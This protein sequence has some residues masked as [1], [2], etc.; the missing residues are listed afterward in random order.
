[1][2]VVQSDLFENLPPE[3]KDRVIFNPPFWDKARD[4]QNPLTYASCD[5]GRNVLKKFLATVPDFLSHTDS[6]V[7]MVFSTQD[8]FSQVERI[9]TT[10]KGLTVKNTTTET[11]G[12][13]RVLFS[14]GRD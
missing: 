5:E 14:L 4:P 6:R 8:N 11:V 9:I 7:V 10:A 1:M 12:H 2:K 13:K 3:K